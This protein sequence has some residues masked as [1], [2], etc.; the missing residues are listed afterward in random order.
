VGGG[1]ARVNG[2][3]AGVE[4]VVF[5]LGGTC[6]ELDHARIAEAVAAR[7]KAPAADWVGRAERAGRA[8]LAEIVAQGGDDSTNHGHWQ[9]FLFAMLE[10]A[11][12]AEADHPAIF[13]ELRAFHQR[14]HLW[15]RVMPGIPETL[16][17]LAGRGYR[18]AAL[19]NSD[20][21]AEALLSRL[22]LA[23]EFEFVVDSREVGVEK[24]DPR[25]FHGACARLGLPASRCAYV[26]DVIPIDVDGARAAGLAPVL[27]DVYGDYAAADAD[28]APRVA[29]PAQLLGLFPDRRDDVRRAARSARR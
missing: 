22:G 12:A 14:H 17:T 26:G 8:R 28:G 13:A 27:L 9:A 10:E 4:A 3:M 16:R 24:P 6:L 25:I 23:H 1:G 2:T 20:G 29:E 15:N 7:G 21:R 19:S 18:V 11:G 5:D